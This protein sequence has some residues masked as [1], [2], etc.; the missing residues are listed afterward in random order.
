MKAVDEGSGP[1]RGKRL[2]RG[3]RGGGVVEKGGRLEEGGAA[4]GE[5]RRPLSIPQ[6]TPSLERLREDREKKFRE[7]E[8]ARRYTLQCHQIEKLFLFPCISELVFIVV[9]LVNETN[10]PNI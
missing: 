2:R 1:V 9:R 7:R 8:R 5:R 3:F 10:K 4:R 6:K